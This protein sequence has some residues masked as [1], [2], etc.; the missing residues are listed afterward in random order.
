MYR[1]DSNVNIVSS[2]HIAGYALL[3][4]L[5]SAKK[6]VGAELTNPEK[7]SFS[8]FLFSALLSVGACL[9][10]GRVEVCKHSSEQRQCSLSISATKAASKGDNT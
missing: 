9:Y 2:R 1:S 8:A 4:P 6:T 3:R 5:S 7:F 10:E